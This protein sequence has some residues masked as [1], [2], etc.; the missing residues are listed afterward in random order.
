M[1]WPVAARRVGTSVCIMRIE[2]RWKQGKGKAVQRLDNRKGQNG[3]RHTGHGPP[4]NAGGG[5]QD[6]RSPGTEPLE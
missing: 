1:D 4:H 2:A 5:G 6:G 3:C